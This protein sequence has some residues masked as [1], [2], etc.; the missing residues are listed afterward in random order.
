MDQQ[1]EQSPATTLRAMAPPDFVGIAALS[2]SGLAIIT[3][4][5]LAPISFVV[6]LFGLRKSPRDLSYIALALSSFGLGLLL[7]PRWLGVSVFGLMLSREVAP[8]ANALLE[9]SELYNFAIDFGNV[10]RG[11]SGLVGPP[12]VSPDHPCYTDHWG[13]RYWYERTVEYGY[14]RF[15]SPGEDQILGTQDDIVVT[16]P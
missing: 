11:D 3:V 9:M 15:V 13:S 6:S 2:L 1:T 16:F 7:V 12:I 8:E 5:L 4:G 14:F 10:S